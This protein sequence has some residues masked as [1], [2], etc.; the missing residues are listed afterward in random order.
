MS[1][2]ARRPIPLPPATGTS[3][4]SLPRG[5][6]T[7]QVATAT[8]YSQPWIRTLAHRYNAGGPDALGDRRQS[9]PGA[10]PLLSP[11][12]QAELA[13]LL[14]GPAP[15]GGIWTGPKVARWMADQLGRSVHPQRGW[16]VL[17]HLGFTLQRLRPRHTQADPEAQAAFKKNSPR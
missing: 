4:G 11:P 17:Q 12:Q 5:P 2:L 10:S 1:A 3:S 16:E 6:P 14:E 9:N 8:G 15:D 7:A 13:T